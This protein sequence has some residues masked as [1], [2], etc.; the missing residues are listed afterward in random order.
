M[1]IL[2]LARIPE[3]EILNCKESNFVK[4]GKTLLLHRKPVLKVIRSGS[5]WVKL[6]NFLLI[7]KKIGLSCV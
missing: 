2:I 5:F 1:V 6:N 4:T 3:L 7:Q